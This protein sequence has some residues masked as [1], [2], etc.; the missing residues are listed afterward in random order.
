MIFREGG[1]GFP[2]LPHF[3][4]PFSHS[5]E[6]A[7]SSVLALELL[8][9]AL[10]MLPDTRKT[11]DYSR[12]FNSQIPTFFFAKALERPLQVAAILSQPHCIKKEPASVLRFWFQKA[13]NPPPACI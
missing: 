6:K 8:L 3:F 10:F 2:F 1:R 4:F 9:L 7:K 11:S 13:L 12:R 5:S